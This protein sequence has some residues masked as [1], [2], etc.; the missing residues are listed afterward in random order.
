MSKFVGKTSKLVY[1]YGMD[2]DIQGSHALEQFISNYGDPYNTRY[3]NSNMETVK[4]SKEIY[5][6][7]NIYFSSTEPH[8][9]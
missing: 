7:S 4:W 1:I 2:T 8:H 6:R 3:D 9:T 5:M